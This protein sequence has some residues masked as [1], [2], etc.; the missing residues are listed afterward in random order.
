MHCRSNS[1]DRYS[2]RLHGW[3]TRG[4]R[5]RSR[6]HHR[7]NRRG[8]CIFRLHRRSDRNRRSD[9]RLNCRNAGLYGWRTFTRTSRQFHYNGLFRNDNTFSRYRP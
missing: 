3:F 4:G 8:R 9:I 6:L 5:S 7:S 2:F 1:R